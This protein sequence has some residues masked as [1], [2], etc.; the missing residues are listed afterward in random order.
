MRRHTR[1]ALVTGVQTCA[2]PISFL[3]LEAL[4]VDSLFERFSSAK[5][6]LAREGAENA[7]ADP[8]PDPRGG[9]AGRKVRPGRRPPDDPT[10]GKCRPAGQRHAPHPPAFHLPRRRTID[11]PAVPPP[12]IHPHQTTP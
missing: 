12:P 2:L 8:A 7:S 10:C 3:S 4:P 5:V 1:C 11:P 6:I 9:S